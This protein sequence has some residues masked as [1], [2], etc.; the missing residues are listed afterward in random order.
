MST[1]MSIPQAVSEEEFASIFEPR[2]KVNANSSNV[3]STLSTTLENIE[4]STGHAR[5]FNL[6]PQQAHWNSETDEL[7]AAITAESNRRADAQNLDDPPP[8]GG[9]SSFIDFPQNF[10]TG[11]YQPYQLPPVPEPWN[12]VEN[13][14]ADAEAGESQELQYRRYTTVLTIDEATDANGE[15]T[16]AAHSSPLKEDIVA[17]TRFLE[18]MQIR[19]EQSRERLQERAMWGISVKRQ[20]KL[21]MKKHKYKKLM[22]RTRNL[23]RRL[24]RN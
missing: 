19:Q 21:K 4:A 8:Q 6:G 9:P 22:K 12:T 23:R 24:D 18:R 3:I 7:R 1:T 10:I 20:R 13:L 17:P 15:V 2:T 14:A 16:Y 11:R 5:E